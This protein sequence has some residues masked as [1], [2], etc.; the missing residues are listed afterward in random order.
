M[1]ARN[2]FVGVLGFGQHVREKKIGWKKLQQ[3][4]IDP[5]SL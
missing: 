2:L 1:G 3:T 4:F 5:Y